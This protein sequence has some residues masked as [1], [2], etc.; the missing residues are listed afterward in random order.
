VP[1]E[2]HGWLHYTNDENPSK[3]PE[4]FI[5]ESWYIDHTPNLTG[6]VNK[7]VPYSTTDHKIKP[8]NPNII[9]I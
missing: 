7:Y 3:N 5:A 8:F 4:L 1:A 6:S 9:F 2:W